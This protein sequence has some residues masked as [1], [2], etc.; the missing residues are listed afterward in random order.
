MDVNYINPFI[1]STRTVF[2][3]MLGIDVNMQ[4]PVLKN[5][6]KS[7]GD[8][9]GVMGLVGDKQ[10]TVAISLTK[11]GAIFIYSS[12]VGDTCD[13]ITTEVVDAIGEITNIISGQARKEFE[14]NNINLSAAIPMVV[15]G[16]NVELNFITIAPI[17][18]L[19]FF[20]SVG[21]DGI[22]YMFIDFSIKETC[23]NE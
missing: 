13:D 8:V 2:S 12:L 23:V 20:F 4:R 21:N 11:K 10:G 18:S 15:V 3:T 19:P 16:K 7:S 17:V 14:K 5:N 1:V 9:T 6:C 22:E